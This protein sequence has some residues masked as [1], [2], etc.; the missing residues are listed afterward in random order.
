MIKITNKKQLELFLKKI[1]KNSTLQ[2]KQQ[3]F[4]SPDPYINKFKSELKDELDELQEQE[5]GEEEPE[6]EPE[7]EGEEEESEKEEEPADDEQGEKRNPAAEKALSLPD[8]E[9]NQEVTAEEILT[10]INLVRA[11]NSTKSKETKQQ[12][13]DY[14][15]KLDSEEQ[16]VLLIYLKEL[17]KIMTGAVDGAEGHDPSDAATYFDITTRK[18]DLESKKPESGAQEKTAAKP[19]LSQSPGQTR[20]EEDTTPP[21]RVN[22]S[23]DVSYIYKKF[24]SINS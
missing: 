18:E 22:E 23:Q 14:F 13:E 16:G 20:G 5:E 3:L 9:V 11:G 10:A 12:I 7:E 24:K 19:Q 8:Y 15:E 6:E 4:E 21:I 2:A 1:A 17:A